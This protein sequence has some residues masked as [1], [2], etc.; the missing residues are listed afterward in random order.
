M[1]T[2]PMS[3]LDGQFTEALPT[4]RECDKCG[5]PMTVQEWDSSCGGF[6]DYK[7]TCTNRPQCQRIYWVDGGDS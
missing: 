6:T 2:A 3:E 7:Y 5:A 1:H 4:E